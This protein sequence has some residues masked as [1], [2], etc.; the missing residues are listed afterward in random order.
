MLASNF[1][2]PEM[3]NQSNFICNSVIN[4]NYP[5]G[6][7]FDNGCFVN[8]SF[9]QNPAY[10]KLL[11]VIKDSVYTTVIDE[12]SNPYPQFYVKH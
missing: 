9:A 11:V 1:C 12:E 6:S 7:I 2:S 8:S 5:G 3:F 10:N 4:S